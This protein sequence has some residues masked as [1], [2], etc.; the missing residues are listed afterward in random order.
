[1]DAGK[2]S[3]LTKA[4]EAVEKARRMV[5]RLYGHRVVRNAA[6]MYAV[7]MSSY[8]FPLLILPYLARV[9]SREKFGLIAFSQMFIW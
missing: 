8:V 6:L 5:E 7:Q 9:L 4:G 2:R 3:D 1:M